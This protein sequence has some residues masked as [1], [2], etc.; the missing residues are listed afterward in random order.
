MAESINALKMAQ[1]QFDHVAGL[2]NLDPQVA[3]VLRC[4][5]R[6]FKFQVPVRM[7]DGTLRLFFG[8]R[9]QHS[10]ARGPA[11]GGIR[12]HPSETLDTVRALGKRE[13]LENYQWGGA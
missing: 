13:N 9:V 12:F 4:P 1:T 3:E 10:D 7:D 11:K 8:Y 5:A 2:L 6:E